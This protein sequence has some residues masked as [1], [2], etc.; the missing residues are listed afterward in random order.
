MI[1]ELYMLQLTYLHAIG[2]QDSDMCDECGQ[3]ETVKHVLK[4]TIDFA[5]KIGGG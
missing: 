3:K 4:A 2:A 1:N 5:T